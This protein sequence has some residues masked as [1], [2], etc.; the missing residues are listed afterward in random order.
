MKL[1]LWPSSLANRTTL[2]VLLALAIVQ[3]AGL[4]IYAFDRR[5][6]QRLEEAQAQA[7]RVMG[8]YRVVIL[9]PPEQRQSM[10]RALDLPPTETATVADTPPEGDFQAVPVSIQ[11]I[12]RLSQR[13]VPIPQ[14]QRPREF[15][16]LWDDA[17]HRL[18]TAIRMP[19][20]RWL[21]VTNEP[22]PLRPWQSEDFLI[23]FAGMT[24]AAALVTLWAARRL[25]APLRVLAAAADRLGR[26]V[27]AAPMRTDGPSEI[28]AAAQAFNT[29][30]GRIRRFVQ[31]RTFLIT[32]IGH[33]LRTPITRLKLRAEFIED[34]EMSRKFIADLDELDAM[35]AA[36]LSFGRDVAGTEP[37]A[38][39][40]LPAL[41]RTVLDE[42]ADAA[43]DYVDQLTYEGPEHLTVHGRPVSIKR[44]I[45][46]L[47][48][49][50]LAYG[51]SAKIRLW[52]PHLGSSGLGGMVK[53]DVADSGPGIPLA[54]IERVFEP[55]HRLEGSRSRE[56]GGT[57][58][59]LPIARNIA[60]A[61]GGDV[62][63]A[64]AASG[65]L[66]AT[67]LLPV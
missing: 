14:E 30:A 13:L 61:H 2:I 4:T 32:A 47:V 62:T 24:A 29:M 58:L 49:N 3:A 42:A 27:A 31:D 59:G 56:T 15:R 26:D 50:A 5:D 9:T 16:L 21:N 45:T 55:F 65:G 22:T 37:I 64:N 38:S 43:P 1:R 33:D 6:L 39:L 67:V 25:T 20:D 17:N 46:N 52:P 18:I 28:A 12:L 40:D 63:L 36:T 19:N 48:N 7:T 44:A 10:L 35:V 34:E 51:G 8:L 41:L 54:E 11:R 66:I 23:A 60:R 57:G 53:V